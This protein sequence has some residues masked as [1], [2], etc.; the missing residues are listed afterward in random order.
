[1]QALWSLSVCEVRYQVNHEHSEGYV[2]A[3]H[4]CLCACPC[5]VTPMIYVRHCTWGQSSVN[6]ASQRLSCRSTGQFSRRHAEHDDSAGHR[7]L[8]VSSSSLP[9]PIR[10]LTTRR[11]R[12]PGQRLV[13][14]DSTCTSSASGMGRILLLWQRLPET[15]PITC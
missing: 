4:V 8:R 7:P 11:G 12:A 14:P 15:V 9:T 10:R 1:M 2:A 3:T 13:R 6:R 5:A